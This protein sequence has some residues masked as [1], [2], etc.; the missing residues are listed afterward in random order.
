LSSIFVWE[1]S[2]KILRI[3]YEG[4]NIHEFCFADCFILMRESDFS[5]GQ[6]FDISLANKFPVCSELRIDR[7]IEERCVNAEDGF[8]DFYFEAKEKGHVFKSFR[9]RS[10][11]GLDG[12]FVPRFSEQDFETIITE[13]GGSKIAESVRKT[14]D[15]LLSKI[16]IELKDI[17]IESLFNPDRQNSIAKIFRDQRGYTVN[18]D[19][20]L[21]LGAATTAFRKLIRNTIKTHFRKA[22]DQIKSFKET[23]QDL[24]SAGIIFLNTGM[25]SLPHEVFKDIVE[26][27]II[28]E[29]RTI[30]FG[31]VFSQVMQSNGW[32]KYAIFCPDFVGDVPTEAKAIKT[33]LGAL[34]DQKMT[35][36]MRT[37]PTT[38]SV[39]SQHPISFC[40]ANKIFYWNPGRMALPWHEH[41]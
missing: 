5:I 7:L 2:M 38:L 28:R 23:Q 12:Y 16:A 34:I 3:M 15:F 20:T 9:D 10:N 19:P 36:M 1:L 32:D 39:G 11:N 27:L 24:V 26:D 37:N 33:K 4:F 6:V 21:E 41:K 14:P 17:Q 30:K 31:L 40:K 25:F 13:L 35:D 18:L 22:S 8:S 29:T